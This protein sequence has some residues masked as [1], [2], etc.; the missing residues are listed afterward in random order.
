MKFLQRLAEIVL[1]RVQLKIYDR[2]ILDKYESLFDTE[3]FGIKEIRKA[4]EE[5][6]SQESVECAKYKELINLC[7]GTTSARWLVDFCLTALLYPEFHEFSMEYWDGITLDSVSGYVEEEFSYKESKKTA[8]CAERILKCQ[9]KAKIFLRYQ[10]WADERLL[11]FFL[12]EYAIDVEL[13]KIG[14][15]VFIGEETLEET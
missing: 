4:Y 6:T 5:L 14:T 1:A 11:D 13:K 8:E 3:L 9:K 12:D 7:G 2:E 15:E 10:F